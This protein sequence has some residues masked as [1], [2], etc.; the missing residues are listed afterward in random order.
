MKQQ[1]A[2]QVLTQFQENPDSWQRVPDI[3]DNAT[4]AQTK[5]SK[6]Y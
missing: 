4:H 1:M 3:L 2:Q 5:V 6:L